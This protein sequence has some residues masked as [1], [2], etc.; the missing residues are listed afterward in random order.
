M[1]NNLIMLMQM[2][3]IGNNPQALIQNMMKNNPQLN[4]IVQQAQ[5]SGDV[6]KFVMQ[7]AKQRNIDIE[8]LMKMVNDRGIKM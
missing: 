7:Y 1:N 5:K 2:L 3:Q 6:K 8:P 4:G